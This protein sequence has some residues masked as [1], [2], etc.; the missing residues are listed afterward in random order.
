MRKELKPVFTRN[1]QAENPAYCFDPGV[2]IIDTR[3][4]IWLI[5]QDSNI[6]ASHYIKWINIGLNVIRLFVLQLQKHRDQILEVATLKDI[7]NATDVS[8]ALL[9][10]FVDP[11]KRSVIIKP[12]MFDGLSEVLVQLDT[13]YLEEDDFLQ[14][15]QALGKGLQFVIKNEK[16]A[17][18]ARY[19]QSLSMLVTNIFDLGLKSLNRKE[20]YESLSKTLRELVNHMSH[21]IR[22][23]SVYGLESLNRLSKNKE[24]LSAFLKRYFN[25]K[26]RKDLYQNIFRLSPDEC[27]NLFEK[28][29][30]TNKN[31]MLTNTWYEPLKFA[32]LLI[33]NNNFLGFERFLQSRMGIKDSEFYWGI[34]YEMKNVIEN[35]F[36]IS[37]RVNTINYLFSMLKDI[38]Q[39][40]LKEVC[41]EILNILSSL[42]DDQAELSDA[43]REGFKG[44]ADNP[45]F[46]N[47]PTVLSFLSGQHKS[48]GLSSR[49]KNQ[50]P[51]VLISTIQEDPNS[52][53]QLSHHKN[54]HALPVAIERKCKM[55]KNRYLTD[56]YISDELAMYIP[57]RGAH[58]RQ[59]AFLT[60]TEAET[61]DMDKTTRDF[62]ESSKRAMLLIGHAGGGKSTFIKFM[63]TKLWNE[64]SEG[65]SIPIFVMLTEL[66]NLTGNLMS[67]TL[68]RTGFTLDETDYIRKHRK[69]ILFLDGYDEAFCRQNLY[70]INKMAEWDLSV[71]VACRSD[72][73]PIRDKHYHKYFVP[74]PDGRMDYDIF[75][76][77]TVVPFSEH[78]IESYI[79]KYLEAQPK[80]QWNDVEEWMHQI[81][82]IPGVRNIIQNPFLLMLTMDVL[83]DIVEKY[84]NKSGKDRVEFQKTSLLDA[85]MEKWFLREEAKLRLKGQ[86]P[87][88]GRDI[89]EDF[90]GFCKDLAVEMQA[91]KLFEVTYVP[92][93]V[94]TANK[95]SSIV[96]DLWSR[97]FSSEDKELV[98]I[99]KA[100]P[101]RRVKPHSWAFYHADFVRYFHN[102][103]MYDER[104]NMD[105]E[106]AKE[107][108]NS[109]LFTAQAAQINKSSSSSTNKQ[110]TPGNFK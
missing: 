58:P 10:A 46:N 98:N 42:K 60:F 43:I 75:E 20:E 5:S 74:S 77:Y 94:E 69:I 37:T 51:N 64:Y 16:E 41:A 23:F 31:D 107:L 8:S 61:I 76:E 68:T 22:F 104:I 78:Q 89:K 91:N 1:S 101:T 32:L 38:N 24:S 59:D 82:L 57:I 36:D 99:R 53:K 29:C 18:L 21:S 97:F 49:K 50:F 12:A 72:Y 14:V 79:K 65:G 34:I 2:A 105:T 40:V 109:N 83:P 33:R 85:F 48:P 3:H 9:E 106:S 30:Q 35:H 63:L 4:L 81:N 93:R 44:L 95:R 39:S 26:K 28:F 84:K 110:H 73:E 108:P 45:D 96:Q 92:S 7:E 103:A 13:T 62:F 80:S 71:I 90:W 17:K 47:D 25:P 6:K 86:L 56:S 19:V 27:V 102:K 70:D 52:I 15:L 55:L 100:S 88:D 67:E 66:Q 87:P 11:I 54:K